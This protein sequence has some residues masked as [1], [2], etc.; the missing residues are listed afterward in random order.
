MGVKQKLGA[1]G[2]EQVAQYLIKL[3]WKILDRNWRIR[4]GELDLVAANSQ[5][6][7]IFIEVKTRSSLAF[8][9]PLEAI[10]VEKALRIQRLAL[11]WMATNQR[12]GCN[13]RID[14]AGVTASKTGEYAIDY[15]EGVL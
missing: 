15:R 8:G 1:N 11:A 12:W 14:V 6:L 10:N 7:L 2:E 5:G 13:Y 4:G 9:D 3:G